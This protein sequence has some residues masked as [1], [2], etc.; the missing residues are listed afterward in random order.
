MQILLNHK[1]LQTEAASL[2]ALIASLNL[3]SAGV[4]AAVNNKLVPRTQWADF[5]LEEGANVT[6]IK[7]ACGG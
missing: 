2:D 7:A 5:K 6:I 3:P 1:E 4:A